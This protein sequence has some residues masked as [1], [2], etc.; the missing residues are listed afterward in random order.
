MLLKSGTV[1]KFGTLRPMLLMGTYDTWQQQNLA[2]A[3]QVPNTEQA[4]KI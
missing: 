2:T 4:L 3:K 1:R